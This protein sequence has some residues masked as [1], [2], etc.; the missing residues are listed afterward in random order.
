MQAASFFTFSKKY[1]TTKIRALNNELSRGI[2]LI[3][4]EDISKKVV[5]FRP[6]TVQKGRNL[7]LS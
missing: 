1:P 6:C 3:L 4:E 7:N 2:K 5:S